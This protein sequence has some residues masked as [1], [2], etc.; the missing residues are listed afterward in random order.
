MAK[1]GI[2]VSNHGGRQLD[3]A[4]ATIDALSQAIDAVPNQVEVFVDKGIRRG[5]DV[6][7]ALA[8]GA[9]AILIG[10]P[11]LWG[12]AVGGE[13]GVRQ[14]LQLLRSGDRGCYGIKWL[15]QAGRYR[16]QFSYKVI[17]N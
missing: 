13:A 14:I 3:G 9:N 6:L 15:C 5:T 16:S 10:R 12:L 1:G 11:V 8:L 7:K 17:P 2:V 4:I